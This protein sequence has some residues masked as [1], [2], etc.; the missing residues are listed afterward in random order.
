[1]LVSN[2]GGADFTV[3]Q[4]KLEGFTETVACTLTANGGPRRRARRWP[5]CGSG[6]SA[7]RHTR[8]QC[9]G[10]PIRRARHRPGRRP[11]RAGAG[12]GRGAPADDPAV[13]VFRRNQ[14]AGCSM[15][16]SIPPAARIT[17]PYWHREGE[18]G[19]YTFDAD[20]PFGLPQRPTPFL[21]QVTLAL[22]SGEE[23]SAAFPIE[24]RYEGD[25]FSG[26]KRSELL[27]VPAFSVRVTPEVL[28]VPSSRTPA[29][30]ATRR[31][32]SP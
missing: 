20:A 2:R 15:T 29:G 21:A 32:A 1:M 25:I 12:R 17:E 3:K 28:I 23:I 13:S 19:R 22:A 27:V 24:Y 6:R 8:Q 4:V 16:A 31:F 9:S 7:R 10:R 5:Q 14:V 18:A 30:V 11:R 26:E